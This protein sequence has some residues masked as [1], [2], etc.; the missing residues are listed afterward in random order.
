MSPEQVDGD[1]AALGPPTDIY[2]LGVLMYEM[3]CARRPFDGSTAAMLGAI[4][5]KDPPKPTDIRPDLPSKL[6]EICLKAMSKKPEDRYSSMAQFAAAL[7]DFLR[8]YKPGQP[9]AATQKIE[10]AAAEPKPA[11]AAAA[12]RPISQFDVDTDD[13]RRKTPSKESVRPKSAELKSG[14]KRPYS[15]RRKKSKSS[16]LVPIL[17]GGGIALTFVSAAI[18]AVVIFW[19]RGDNQ[20]AQ[21]IANPGTTPTSQRLAPSSQYTPSAPSS[22]QR[23]VRPNPPAPQPARPVGFTLKVPP[24]PLTLEV[25][26]SKQFTVSVERKEFHGPIRLNIR[27][28]REVRV[29]PG[30]RLTLNPNQSDATLTAFLT[31]IPNAGT[32]MEISAYAEDTTQFPTVSARLE[33]RAAANSDCMRIVELNSDPKF[34]VEAAAF[35]PDLSHALVA[36]GNTIHIWDLSRGSAAGKLD[37]HHDRVTSVSISADG[38]LALSTSVDRTVI[39]W[40]LA[41]RK[42]KKQSVDVKKRVLG[43][44]MS[45]AGHRGIVIYLGSIVRVNLDTFQ[46]LL[47]TIPVSHLMGSNADDAIQTV[48]LSQERKAILGGVDGKLFLLELP[49]KPRMAPTK[50]ALAGPTDT[51]LCSAFDRGGDLAASGGKDKIVRVWDVAGHSLKWKSEGVSEA[52]VCVRFSPDGSMLATGESGGGIRVWSATDGKPIAKFSGQTNPILALA[53]APDGKSLWSASTDKSLRQ[54]RLP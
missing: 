52:V 37:G 2:S 29:T 1:N 34:I 8:N 21:A 33:V 15:G 16:P 19:P 43:A 36:A 42:L 22:A 44:A 17:V 5:T 47:P 20:T 14:G 9:I 12:T 31:A 23:N 35:T 51:V 39:L 45:P 41:I 27:A 25:G 38:S 4:M 50:H 30:G 49:D 3:M 48:A 24:E 28:P 32:R 13:G 53:F 7:A 26:H 40:D 18:A 10:R 6:E 11:A 46:P 54:W